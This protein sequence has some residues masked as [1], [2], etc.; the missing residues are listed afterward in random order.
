[1]VILDILKYK[2][3]KIKNLLKF[4]NTCRK[5]FLHILFN[6]SNITINIKKRYNKK[7]L[8]FT[9]INKKYN[10]FEHQHKFIFKKINYKMYYYV[11]YLDQH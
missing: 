6:I 3:K 1:M 5:K 9:F 4:F 7:I 2:G 11:I 8:T 10:H